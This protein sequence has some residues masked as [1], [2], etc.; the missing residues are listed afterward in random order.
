MVV[1]RRIWPVSVLCKRYCP[2]NGIRVATDLGRNPA[3]LQSLRNSNSNEQEVVG[4]LVLDESRKRNRPF[5]RRGS[6][7]SAGF[8]YPGPSDCRDKTSA[9]TL[10]RALATLLIVAFLFISTSPIYAQSKQHNLTKLKTDARD[11]VG[12]IGG[13]K[14]KTQTYCQ[15]IALER[16]FIQAVSEKDLNK[17]G[18]LGQ[19]IVQLRKQ[20]PEAVV[21]SNIIKR[22]DLN[23]PDGQEILSIIQSLDQSCPD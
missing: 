1:V 21:L 4:F 16:Q 3:S 11:T 5:S 7:Y 17:A 6:N 8:R 9:P 13:D 10:K 23:S 20:V 14:A 15:I 22:V 18:A 12:I 2:R 19:D